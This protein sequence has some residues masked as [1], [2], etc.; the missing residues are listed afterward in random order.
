[1]TE[2]ASQ[3]LDVPTIVRRTSYW[4]VELEVESDTYLLID[5]ADAYCAELH[6]DSRGECWAHFE[7]Y[8]A[9]S[10]PTTIADIERLRTLA[11]LLRDLPRP[12]GRPTREPT[13][14]MIATFQRAP[15]EV[16]QVSTLLEH[17]VGNTA[18]A[19]PE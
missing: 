8:T 14:P 13:K 1:M 10:G 2:A 7:P 3:H 16:S 17:G 18:N 19:V 6:W 15:L 11:E 9:F 5:S 4:S 12:A